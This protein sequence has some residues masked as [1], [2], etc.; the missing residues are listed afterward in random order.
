MN[1][2]TRTEDPSV[3]EYYKLFHQQIE[4]ENETISQKMMW[5]M[6]SQSFFFGAFASLCGAQYPLKQHLLQAAYEWMIWI[7]PVCALMIAVI[8]ILSLL[9]SF[10]H[11][12]RITEA[13][14]ER[15]HH[16]ADR[17]PPM[18]KDSDTRFI[19]KILPFL[20]PL[21][22]AAGWVIILFQ[23]IKAP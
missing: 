17:L 14:K 20:I 1:D 5:N 23:Y 13:F 12:N 22:F 6:V 16:L 21:I 4:K 18:E 3:L 7:I 10:A 11:V 15:V 2:K 8:M 19:A 9:E